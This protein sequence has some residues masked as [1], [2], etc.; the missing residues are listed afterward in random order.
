[1]TLQ[2]NSLATR[3]AAASRVAVV[4]SGIA[5]LSTAWLLADQYR[6]TLFEAGDYFGGHSNT[7]DV[8][9]E[10]VTHPVDTGFLVHNDLTY[11]NL[12]PLLAYLGVPVHA[13]DM[14]FGVSIHEPDIEWA[15]TN[16]RS[17]F[18]QPSNL[19][20]PKFLGMLR[21]ILRF[22][23]E[24][25]R[26]LL[27]VRQ[28]PMTL[29]ALLTREKFGRPMQEWYLLPMAA[30]IWSAPVSAVLEFSAV[31]FLSFCLNHRLLQIENRPQWKTILGGS[32]LYVQA[33]LERLTDARLT[34][35]V[36]Q[37]RRT[38]ESVVVSS[39]RGDESF[40]AVVMACHAPTTLAL[41]DSTPNEQRVLSGFDYQ[42]NEA[43]LHTDVALLPRRQ[44]V[45]S[46]WNYMAAGGQG[47]ERPVAVSYLINQLQPLPFKTPVIVTLN[48]HRPPDPAKVIARFSY[49]HPVLDH[50]AS[51]AQ[52][53][54]PTLQGQQR[55]WFCGA[56]TGFGFHE[57]GLKSALRV[58]RAFG[59]EP[60]WQAT[61]D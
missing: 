1:M 22:N 6:V 41:L 2:P 25:E 49:E 37:V 52:S 8:T 60:P 15:G 20:R 29:G 28:T 55:T 58:A 39:P 45:W 47:A 38:A 34:C 32:R 48:P 59:V 57:D 56:W 46:A 3:P 53:E 5:G 16:L 14:S 23:R 30:A 10:G 4:G 31:T 17:V 9:L 54:L 43:I 13:S 51:L 18:A 11:P 26:Y 21:D 33:M 7:V 42:T 12:G 36:T 24:A 44:K 40:D 61:Y 50:A 35:P 27:E 19:L